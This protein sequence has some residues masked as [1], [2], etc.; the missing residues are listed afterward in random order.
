MIVYEYQLP[1]PDRPIP[2]EERLLGP[3]G[4][5]LPFFPQQLLP[6]DVIGRRVDEVCTYVG[7]YGMGGAGFFGL[8]LDREWLVVAI[9]GAGE[10]I[11][12][13][14]RL[15]TDTFAS[16]YNRPRPWISGE[17]DDLTGALVG[18]T[19]DEIAVG[20]HSL[21][22]RIADVQLTIDEIADRRPIQEGDKQPRC[23]LPDDD[24]RRAV[25]LSPTTEI[26][27]S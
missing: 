16:K 11:L 15:I 20:P 24:L 26:W 27:V 8:R 23:F 2:E 4:E 25:F 12:A 6:A 10:W 9:W 18:R 19:I 1:D 13:N 22:M 7:T 14:D 17:E 3:S 21:S 5:L